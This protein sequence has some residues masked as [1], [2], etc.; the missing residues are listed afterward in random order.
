MSPASA[1]RVVFVVVVGFSALLSSAPVAAMATGVFGA[2]GE[3]PAFQCRSCHGQNGPAPTALVVGA[4]A[5]LLPGSS[6]LLTVVV[7][8]AADSPGAAAGFN[9]S[10]TSAGI[11]VDPDAGLD[12]LQLGGGSGADNQAT[13]ARPKP[14]DVD[15]AASWRIA[16][17]DL[18]E[19]R[20][21]VFV[22]VND[23]DEDRLVSNDRATLLSVP[24]LVCDPEGADDDDDDVTGLC[25]L[26]PGIADPAQGDSDNDGVG[27]ACDV[28]PDVR[29]PG[30]ADLD[31]DGLGDACDTDTDECAL[32]LNDCA[33]A[34]ACTDEPFIGFSCVCLPGTEGDGRT[35]LDVDECALSL[36]DCDERARCDNTEGSFTCTCA[37]GFAGDGRA[38]DDVDECADASDDCAD[39]AACDNVEGSFT[40]ACLPGLQGDG[41]DC[42]DVDECATGVDDCGANARCD[43]EAG[44]FSCACDDGYSGDGVDCVD[45]DECAGDPCASDERC[46]NTDGAF[47]CTAVPATDEPSCCAS[48]GTAPF[49]AFLLALL[50]RRRR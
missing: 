17:T 35:C 44:S 39:D 29:D 8:R 5:T 38:C 1:A 11:L 3:N 20:H 10:T 33:D 31:E 49:A 47:A 42:V 21:R 32:G 36:D 34:A 26:C 24:L 23:V 12:D 50:R 6:V 4:D 40:C 46:D 7:Q 14:Y 30:Q 48:V 13:H 16:L 15:G 41:R 18:R 43:N 28:C 22:G 19:G 45:V 27:D 2:S 9:L 37:E 25:D